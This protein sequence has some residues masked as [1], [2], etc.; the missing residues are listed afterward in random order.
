MAE[1]GRP[2]R[3]PDAG[4]QHPPVEGG[5]VGG[6]GGRPPSKI[7]ARRGQ[8][9]A[10]AGASLTISQVIPWTWVNSTR[11]RGG[12]SRRL[13]WRTTFKPSTRTSPTA[14]ALSGPWSA[15]SKSMATNAPSGGGSGRDTGWRRGCMA[16]LITRGMRPVTVRYAEC[17]ERRPVARDVNGV[18]TTF[19]YSG[20]TFASPLEARGWAGT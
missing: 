7:G 10:N 4:G 3:R 5:V 17:G 20:R 18:T 1:P 15:V 6:Q 19:P 16:G 12:R 13:S 8:A 9:S 11:C 2:A 14:Q